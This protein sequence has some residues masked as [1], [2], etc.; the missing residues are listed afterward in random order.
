MLRLSEIK[1]PSTTPKARSRPR[2]ARASRSWRGR[3]RASVTP[4]SAVRTM[5]ASA[6]TSSSRISSMSKSRMRQPRS[7]AR[8][9]A[10][11]RRDARHGV[12]LRHE[13]ARARQFPAPGRDRHGA[14]RPVR[15]ADPRADGF[16]PHHP[17]TRQG[18]ARAH[19][20]HLRPVA[21]ERAQPRI[22]R[23]VRRRRCRDVFRRQAVQP[24]QG[25]EP[26]WPQGAGRIRQGRC[27]RR[28]PVSEPAAHRHVPPRQHGGKDARVH[29]RTGW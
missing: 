21:Q 8:R 13:G 18:R 19:Q 3:G 27:A 23:A 28:H 6:P 17:R 26:L 10:A 9:Q 15:G 5:R 22:Q 29:P 25:P 14:V 11:L 4:C 7:S 24:D 12:P 16:P 1:L 2:F 20:G